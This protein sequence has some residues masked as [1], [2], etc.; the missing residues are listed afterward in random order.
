M[1]NSCVKA[2]AG[3]EFRLQAALHCA[4]QAKAWTPNPRPGRPCHGL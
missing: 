3:S 2:G 1:V 4:A